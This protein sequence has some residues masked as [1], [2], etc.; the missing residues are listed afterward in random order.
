MAVQQLRAALTQLET[1]A[2]ESLNLDLNHLLLERDLEC[3]EGMRRSA[4]GM[5]V[6]GAPIGDDAFCAQ[7]VGR[8]VDA[9]W[10]SAAPRAASTLRWACCCCASAAC[11]R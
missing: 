9:A 7:F 11:K 1:D 6:A 2:K 4:D 5:R 3:F 8:K 10:P